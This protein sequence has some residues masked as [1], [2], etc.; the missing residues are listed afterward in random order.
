M[1]KL[2]FE[3][4]G[5]KNKTWEC[6]VKEV[7]ETALLR[8]IRINQALMSRSLSFDFDGQEGNVY[9]G[10]RTVGTFKVVA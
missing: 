2:R 5:S 10:F 1:I 8:Q 9:A 4:V 3:N 7:T 6:R